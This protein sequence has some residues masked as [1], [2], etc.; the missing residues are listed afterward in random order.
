MTDFSIDAVVS[1]SSVRETEDQPL[2]TIVLFSC[3]GLIASLCLMMFGIDLSA[4]WI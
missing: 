1:I 4:D 3:A 2:K